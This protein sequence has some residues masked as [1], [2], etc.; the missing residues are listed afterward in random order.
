MTSWPR[1]WPGRR[2]GAGSSPPCPSRR[3]PWGCWSR[4]RAPAPARRPA[5]P[6]SA[7]CNR[8]LSTAAT[9]GPGLGLPSARGAPAPT[10]RAALGSPVSSGPV[11]VSPLEPR[12]GRPDGLGLGRSGRRGAGLRRGGRS[13]ASPRPSSRSAHRG[14][15]SGGRGRPGRGCLL[16]V[17]VSPAR[18]GGPGA[19]RR[20][21]GRAGGRA[22]RRAATRFSVSAP[23]PQAPARHPP[24]P[25][26]GLRGPPGD[27]RPR[28][29]QDLGAWPRPAPP[30]RL[31]QPQGGA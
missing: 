31:S 27:Q 14:V 16:L 24:D 12:A 9:L 19:G 6:R 13:P 10:P 20:A 2:P 8:L 7:S 5:R 3:R 17:Q 23:R 1:S 18:A 11:H 30:G 28:H 25:E 21:R 26:G 29:A 4:V 15:L 22:G